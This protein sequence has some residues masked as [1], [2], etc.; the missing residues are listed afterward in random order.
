MSGPGASP[1]WSAATYRTFVRADLH[2]IGG[3]A[4]WKALVRTLASNPG[5]AYLFWMRTCRFTRHHPWLRWLA[6]P[7]ARLAFT[8][9]HFRYGISIPFDT[10]IGPGFFIGHFGGIVVNAHSRIGRNCNISHG[11]T[12]GQT[13]RGARQG[14]PVIGDRVYIGP[15]AKVIGAVMVGDGA[16]IGANAVVTRDV[17]PNA[18]VAGAPAR[19]V[20]MGGST[21][22]VE[23]TYED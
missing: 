16:A 11:V 5:F 18:V 4:G 22:Y 13:N 1:A 3:R 21:G 6:Y 20:S 9:C 8:R 10:E 17:P 14:C 7:L 2:R 15:G 23:F 12:L 19:V